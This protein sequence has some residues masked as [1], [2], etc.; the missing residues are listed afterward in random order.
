M[1]SEAFL[2]K[3]NRSTFKYVLLSIGLIG[4]FSSCIQLRYTDYGRPFDFLKAKNQY[5]RTNNLEIDT[6]T[7]AHEEPNS[8]SATQL[9]V[10]VETAELQEVASDSA[11]QQIFPDTTLDTFL[12]NDQEII[13]LETDKN[14]TETRMQ[15]AT[16]QWKTDRLVFSIKKATNSTPPKWW[17]GFWRFILKLFLFA[18]LGLIALIGL[19]IGIY[20]FVSWIGGTIAAVI[21]VSLLLIALQIFADIDLFWIFTLF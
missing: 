4:V 21:V 5:H 12:E 1:Y 17:S 6:A 11:F 16:P 3:I 2:S 20:Y 13:A 9:D 8:S 19:T 15:I 7:I 10:V 18:L 14:P